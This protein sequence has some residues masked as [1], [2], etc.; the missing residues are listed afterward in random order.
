LLSKQRR[1]NASN[2]TLIGEGAPDGAETPKETL[3]SNRAF[4]ITREMNQR[5]RNVSI[6]NVGHQNADKVPS[7]ANGPAMTVVDGIAQGVTLTVYGDDCDNLD[8]LARD[9]YLATHNK[10]FA[11]PDDDE[12]VSNITLMFS[13]MDPVFDDADFRIGERLRFTSVINSIAA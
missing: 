8:L 11:L 4:E 7:L 1:L 5:L 12:M 3:M 13:R 10:S 2:H 9:V 6:H